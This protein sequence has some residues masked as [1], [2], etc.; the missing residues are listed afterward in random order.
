[1]RILWFIFCSLQCFFA[2][3]NWMNSFF[4]HNLTFQKW[5]KYNSQDKCFLCV[6]Q[7][8]RE[9]LMHSV[10]RHCHPVVP[11]QT[12]WQRPLVDIL[13]FHFVAG[14]GLRCLQGRW[15]HLHGISNYTSPCCLV[16]VGWVSG[17]SQCVNKQLWE[18]KVLESMS[19]WTGRP[20]PILGFGATVITPRQ[21]RP[22]SCFPALYSAHS[23]TLQQQQQPESTEVCPSP[24][25]LH[26]KP[27]RPK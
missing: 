12:G 18:N 21:T 23:Y 10:C 1:M 7:L 19:M 22:R 9:T 11:Q 17:C 27:L 15:T 6:N 14:R 16:V 4:C 26:R 24:L 2:V 8:V 3:N 25:Q 20:C 5:V 13:D